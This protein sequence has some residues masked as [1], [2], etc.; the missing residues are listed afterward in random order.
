MRNRDCKQRLNNGS[1]S[2]SAPET[3]HIHRGDRGDSVPVWCSMW[4][5]STGLGRSLTP[6]HP[7]SPA[8]LLLRDKKSITARPEKPIKTQARPMCVHLCLPLLSCTSG[9]GSSNFSLLLTKIESVHISN[10]I[11]P[12]SKWTKCIFCHSFSRGNTLLSA[13]NRVYG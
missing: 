2:F 1:S 4:C 3:H 8:C 10:S 5:P 9:F 11:E 12:V 6:R 13:P 7:S